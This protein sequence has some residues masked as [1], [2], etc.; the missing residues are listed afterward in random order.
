MTSLETP[1]VAAGGV[2]SLQDIKKA[3]E[4]GASALVIGTALYEREVSFEKAK[5]I[6]R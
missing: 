1:L 6:A 5:E 2:K 3:R 4:A